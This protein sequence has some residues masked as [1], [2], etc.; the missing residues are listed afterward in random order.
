MHATCVQHACKG[1]AIHFTCKACM[2]T[3]VSSPDPDSQ[4]LRV[5]YITAF[6]ARIEVREREVHVRGSEEEWKERDE[7]V[8]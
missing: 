4:Q 1:S 2:V 7:R 8:Y 5:D 6:S 3:L